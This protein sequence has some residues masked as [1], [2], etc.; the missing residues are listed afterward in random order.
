MEE[1]ADLQVETKASKFSR[2]VHDEE[3]DQFVLYWPFGANRTGL[4]IEIGFILE[5]LRRGEIT[6]EN[7]RV[8]IEDDGPRRRA[9]GEETAE[10]G[11][12]TFVSY[13]KGHRS[14][15]YGD[16]IPF[17]AILTGW[18]SYEELFE[19]LKNAATD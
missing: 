18:A 7:V 16:L 9:G 6:G 1:H 8:L 17:G 12:F 3:I 2:L 15:Y 10:D 5:K 4:D 13:E 19:L 11:T 14:T